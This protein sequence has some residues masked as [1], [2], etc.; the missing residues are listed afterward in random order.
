MLDALRRHWPEYTIEAAALGF[1]MMSAC[2]FG[3]AFEHPSSPLNA[4][5]PPFPRRVLTGLAMGAT[6]IAIVYSPFGKRSG[7]HIN[8]AFTLS[9]F[10]L[11]KI[12]ASDA[13]FYVLAQFAGAVGGVVVAS[14]LL[15]H[16]VSHPSVNYAATVP[17]TAGVP[18]AFAA[19]LVM[20][21]VMMTV[22][23]HATNTK[24]VARFTGLFAGLLVAT[25]IS[26]EVPVSG[27]SI[28]PA[29]TFGSAVSA[30]SWTTLWLYFTA[31][32]LGMLLASELY[33]IT[34]GRVLCAKLHHDNDERCIFRC[35]YR[36]A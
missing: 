7:A 5:L 27:M 11:G 24:R 26:L 4:L 17:G 9:F 14:S 6:A 18:A 22:V 23:L 33:R 13:M 1:F 2:F 19:E 30:R 16:F 36:K 3:V 29:R 8:P 31:P 25:F 20:A 32:P 28:N 15:G 21:F 34:R 35:E 12:E 10:R